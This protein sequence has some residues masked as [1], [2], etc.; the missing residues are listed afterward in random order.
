VIK[1]VWFYQ[2]KEFNDATEIF[3]SMGVQFDQCDSMSAS[4]NSQKANTIAACPNLFDMLK[5]SQK[6]VRKS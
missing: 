6:K 3:R 4:S 2:E 5:Q 1:C